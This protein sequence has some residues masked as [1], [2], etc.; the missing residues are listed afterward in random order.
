MLNK[1]NCNIYN[2]VLDLDISKAPIL[3]KENL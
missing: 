1:N 2:L 3:L